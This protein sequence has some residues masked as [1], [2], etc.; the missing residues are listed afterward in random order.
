MAVN[1]STAKQNA[2]SK[3]QGYCTTILDTV[4]AAKQ[5]R[6]ECI[7]AGFQVGGGDAITDAFL[8]GAGGVF[9]QLAAADLTAAFAAIADI[10]TTLSATSRADYKALQKL[11]P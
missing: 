1:T 6:Q 5:L 10:D 8:N 4:N 7:D 2:I 11:R 3:L 9:P